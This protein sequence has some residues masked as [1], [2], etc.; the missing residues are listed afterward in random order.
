MM[1]ED[2]PN[3]KM[4]DVK[5]IHMDDGTVFFGSWTGRPETMFMGEMPHT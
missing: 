1:Y 5:Q 4:G 3:R 2:W